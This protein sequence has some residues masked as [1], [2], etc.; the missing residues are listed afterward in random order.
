MR[1]IAVAATLVALAASPAGAQQSVADVLT[2]IVTNQ[3]VATGNFERDRAAAQATSDTIR[4]ALL[5]S[6]ATLPVTTSSGAFAYRL[7]PELGTVERSTTSFGPFFIERALTAGNGRAS[8]GL[9]FQHMRFSSLDGHNLRDGSLVTT[10]NQFVDEKSPFD[11]DQLTLAIDADVATLYGNVGVTDRLEFGFAVPMVRLH[12]E[13][14]RVDVYRGQPFTQAR[15]SAT[16]VGP[17][18]VVLRS[19]VNV[20]SESGQSLAAAVDVRLPTGRSEDLLGT[21]SSSVKFSGIGSIESG[22]LSAHANAGFALGGLAREFSYGGAGAVAANPRLTISAELLG[23]WIDTS[24]GINQVFSP[25]PNLVGVETIRLLP[26]GTGLNVITAVP[27]AK[28]N[29]SKT[30][31]LAANVTFPL[32]K[33]GLTAPVTPFVGIDYSFGK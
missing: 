24:S 9:T 29:L 19:K 17:A 5:A 25:N 13:G 18:D 33:G 14:S 26:S 8:F 16:A 22:I 1:T 11:V 27:G 4:Q 3:A 15:A 21:G 10:A 23:R 2:F 20:Y 31:V 6:L 12:L 32:T 30:W 7:N 28:W